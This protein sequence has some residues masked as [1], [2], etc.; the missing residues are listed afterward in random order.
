MISLG[1]SREVVFFIFPY[2]TPGTDAS[3][4]YWFV[5]ISECWLI[6]K[7]LIKM[8]TLRSGN[9][10]RRSAGFIFVSD[11]APTERESAYHPQPHA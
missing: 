8:P 4:I 5:T 1:K 7:Y 2:F 9:S 11:F 6:S 3:T 10:S